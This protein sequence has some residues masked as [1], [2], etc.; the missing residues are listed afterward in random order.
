MPVCSA[1]LIALIAVAA[2][3]SGWT[4]VLGHRQ[5]AVANQFVDL[6]QQCPNAFRVAG[7]HQ[8]QVGVVERQVLPE[9]VE[10]DAGVLVDI[11]LTDLD[12]APAEGQQ[13]QAGAL[14]RADQRVEH[15]VDAIPIGVATDLVGEIG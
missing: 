6:A 13:L 1:A 8:C 3:V 2:S 5:H 12:E 15:H 7:G 14:G 9:R 4:R 11:A 10:V